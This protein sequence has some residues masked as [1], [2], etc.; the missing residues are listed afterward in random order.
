MVIL[1]SRNKNPVLALGKLVRLSMAVLLCGAAGWSQAPPDVQT[2]KRELA[3]PLGTE[4]QQ[5]MGSISGKVVDQSGVNIEGVV[6]KLAREGESPGPEVTSDENGRFA[7]S[8][9][10]PGPFRLT[11]TSE[12]LASQEF[13]GS[14]DPGEAYVT[15]LITL[16]IPAQVTEMRVELTPEELADTQVKQQEKQRVLGIIPNFY[17][18]YVPD[19]AP[20]RPK[21]KFEL[22]WKSAS[23]P[24]T[25][26]GVG[27]LA[28]IDQAT[29]RWPSYGQGMQGYAKRYGASYP[30]VF[31]ATF[32]GGAVLPS[33]LKQDPRY[34]YKGEG[35][36]RSRLLHAIATS[37]IC[38]GDSGHWQ[39]NYSNVAGSFAAAGI[40]KLYYPASDS[41]KASFVVSTALI[42]IG[43]TSLAGV[44][45]E[46]VFP[47]LTPNRP[48]RSKH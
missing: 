18:S 16:A 44:L 32:I 11:I 17:V 42:R 4:Q 41:R 46:F 13:S 3:D 6:V 8:G 34:Y 7:F 38:K 12:G 1:V 33:I 2:A 5:R 29:N 20:L 35:T 40:A 25:F 31:A 28:G 14:E 23:D 48:T 27:V 9:V 24:V 47:K 10:A 30:N 22:A 43:E 26:L 37:V 19:A 45:Q 15:P 36:K 21:E 39:P